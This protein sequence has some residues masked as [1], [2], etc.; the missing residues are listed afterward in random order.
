MGNRSSAPRVGGAESQQGV[1]YRASRRVIHLLPSVGRCTLG[2]LP[3]CV[4]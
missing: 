3:L 2:F 4:P 1:S